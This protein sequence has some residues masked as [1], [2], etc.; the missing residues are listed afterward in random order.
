MRTSTIVRTVLGIASLALVA[1][2]HTIDLQA[3]TKECFFEDLHT[4]DKVRY[5]LLTYTRVLTPLNERETERKL[6][7][8]LTRFVSR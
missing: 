4:E 7:R 8:P 5:I 3:G 1:K 6:T 2:S